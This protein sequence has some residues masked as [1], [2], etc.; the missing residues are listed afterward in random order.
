MKPILVFSILLCSIQLIA[1]TKESEK[2]FNGLPLE[3][4]RELMIDKLLRDTNKYIKS[5]LYHTRIGTQNRNPYS[6]LFVINRKQYFK[7]DIVAT[8]CVLEFIDS[9]LTKSNLKSIKKLNK[10]IG[11]ALYGTSGMNGVFVLNLKKLKK[12]RTENCGFVESKKRKG[13]NLNQWKKGELS[14]QNSG[15]LIQEK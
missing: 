4:K 14:I 5:D 9:Y 11:T 1:Q 7:F 12:A 3:E 8:E 15:I 13:S 6:E 2:Y 10:Q